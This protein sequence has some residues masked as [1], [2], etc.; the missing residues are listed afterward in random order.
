M[1]F[2]D[3][4][5]QDFD[6]FRDGFQDYR[7]GRRILPGR[8]PVPPTSKYY[9]QHRS[10]GARP[11]APRLLVRH[12][13]RQPTR[14]WLEPVRSQAASEGSLLLMVTGK[15]NTERIRRG[16]TGRGDHFR[17]GKGDGGGSR[18]FSRGESVGD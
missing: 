9:H 3:R 18:R 2:K 15:L 1:G 10:G 4:T 14:H 6:N 7:G 13:Q 11:E 5:T 12:S 8:P 16:G 17:A